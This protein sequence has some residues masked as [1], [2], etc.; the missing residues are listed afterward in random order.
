MRGILKRVRKAIERAREQD[1]E[2][3]TRERERASELTYHLLQ[4]A[5]PAP[6]QSPAGTTH[7]AAWL[8]MFWSPPPA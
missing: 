5:R 7:L 2:I 6:H 3:R 1:R 8:C 4:S